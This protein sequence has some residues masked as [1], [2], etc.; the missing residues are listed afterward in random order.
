MICSKLLVICI[1]NLLRGDD[2]AAHYL[3]VQLAQTKFPARINIR[4]V[5]QLLP[6]YALL[7]R[8]VQT[9]VFVDASVSLQPGEVKC[10][11]VFAVNNS[12][13]RYLHNMQ[14]GI[15]LQL[16]G[17][18]MDSPPPA[19][20]L[21]IGAKAFEEAYHLSPEVWRAMPVAITKFRNLISLLHKTHTSSGVE[22][23]S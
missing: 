9:V 21:T 12:K 23:P 16:A 11:R 7:L 13:I 18:I 15:L 6:E 19:Y 8:D 4:R 14:P 20:Q 3:G 5:H 2:G 1:G 17:Q 22:L 10:E